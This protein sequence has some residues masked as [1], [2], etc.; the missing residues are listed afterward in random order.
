MDVLLI[1]GYIALAA[2]IVFLSIKLS[3]YVDILDKTTKLSGAL[4][5]GVLLAAVTSLP[6]L[7]TSMT[8]V[9]GVGQ[10]DLVLGN[11]LGSDIFDIVVLALLII[12]FIKNFTRGRI[13]RCHI[14][15]FA[16]LLALYGVACLAT[17]LPAEIKKYIVLG[18]WFNIFA[19]LIVVLY[20]I[21]LFSLGK[22][23]EKEECT[24]K[25]KITKKQLAIRFVI[26]ALLLVGSSIGITF[27]SDMIS[28]KYN[29]GKTVAGALLLGVMTSLP[30]VVSTFN[31]FLKKNVN[32][33]TGNIV[34]S[35]VFNYLIIAI[36][37]LLSFNG[38]V[39]QHTTASF[40][41]L[42]F[43]IM[44]TA[45]VFIACLIKIF[46]KPKTSGQNFA[47]VSI[48]IFFCLVSISGYVLFLA[49]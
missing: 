40:N 10:P 25:I 3:D 21:A 38:S 23:E 30:E 44:S 20:G 17:L 11:I 9:L 37:E 7:F 33:G 48:E 14:W 46:F 16:I 32:A 35:C 2:L 49:L 31:L 29:I 22:T 28:D 18:G 5:G 34:G 27:I 45:A 6:E 8:A 24:E 1:L 13:D 39:F 26:A 15:Q 19:V 12:I 42:V 4:L 47:A 36:C 43:G 41:L